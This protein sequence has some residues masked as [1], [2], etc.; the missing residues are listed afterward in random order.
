MTYELFFK[1]PA[2]YIDITVDW[3]LWLQGDTITSSNW[4]VP[5]ELTADAATHTDQTTTVWLSGGVLGEHY[6][7]TNTITTAAGRSPVRTIV[8]RL[9]SK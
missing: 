6:L 8:V 9:T 5:Q 1:A 2:E 3:N 7:L 4:D